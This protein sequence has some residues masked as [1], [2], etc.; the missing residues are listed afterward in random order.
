MKRGV[1]YTISILGIDVQTEIPSEETE[2][3]ETIQKNDE[4]EEIELIDLKGYHG[5]ALG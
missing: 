3:K 5:M 2:K 1:R 4:K